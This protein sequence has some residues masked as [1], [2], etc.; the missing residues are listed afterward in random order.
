[1]VTIVC[2]F[3]VSLSLAVSPVLANGSCTFE[4]QKSLHEAQRIVDSLRIDKTGQMRVFAVDGSDY[5][6]GEVLWMK[7]EL[8]DVTAACEKGDV[9]A[10]AQ[11]L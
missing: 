5:S 9:A 11:H 7:G 1:M 4:M 8:R 3:V 10:A 2:A 6:G